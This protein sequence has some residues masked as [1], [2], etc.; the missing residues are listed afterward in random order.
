MLAFEGAVVGVDLVALA[1]V[2]GLVERMISLLM[3]FVF[4]G[5]GRFEGGM[6]PGD[7]RLAAGM[8]EAFD[9]LRGAHDPALRGG[10]KLDGGGPRDDA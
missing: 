5:L 1:Q 8:A 3:G 4:V 6:H 9:A 7:T 10:V 2:D